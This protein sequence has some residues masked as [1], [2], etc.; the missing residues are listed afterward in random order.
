[1][2]YM[3]P[4]KRSVAVLPILMG[5]GAAVDIAYNTPVVMRRLFRGRGAVSRG[6]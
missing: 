6:G 2:T 3:R 4:S 5:L 1:M